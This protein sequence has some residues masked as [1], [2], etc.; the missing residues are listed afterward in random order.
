MLRITRRETDNGRII[1]IPEGR[2]ASDWVSLLENE[3]SRVMQESPVLGLD[4]SEVTCLDR[5]GVE[6]LRRLQRRGVRIVRASLIVKTLLE[7]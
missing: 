3:C 7:E 2:I 5:G 6:L 1:L 4:L